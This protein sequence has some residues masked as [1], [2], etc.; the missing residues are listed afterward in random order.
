[1]S[2]VSFVENV[3][4]VD[5]DNGEAPAHATEVLRMGMGTDRVTAKSAA[6]RREIA[7]KRAVGRR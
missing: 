5:G 1:M 4:L 3:V 2:G 6:Q 7:N